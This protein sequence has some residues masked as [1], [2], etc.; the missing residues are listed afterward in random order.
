MKAIVTMR[1]LMMPLGKISVRP[2]TPSSAMQTLAPWR[3]SMARL[4]LGQT[5]TTSCM[6]SILFE[7]NKGG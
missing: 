4:S 3:T 5:R 7:P 2:Q 6:T 1:F